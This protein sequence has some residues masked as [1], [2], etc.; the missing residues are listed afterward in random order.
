MGSDGTALSPA[1]PP[2][3]VAWPLS[4]GGNGG[5]PCGSGGKTGTGGRTLRAPTAGASGGASSGPPAE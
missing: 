3:E 2:G 4:L 5:A 1:L